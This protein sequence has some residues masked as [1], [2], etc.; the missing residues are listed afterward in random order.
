M[1]V[2]IV[3]AASGEESYG[4]EEITDCMVDCARTA[5]DEHKKKIEVL[6]IQK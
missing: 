6:S 5:K 4:V 2:N 3:G 1:G